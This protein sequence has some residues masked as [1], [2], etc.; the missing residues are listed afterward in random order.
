[1]QVGSTVLARLHDGR[2]VVVE[3]MAAADSGVGRD[4]LLGLKGKGTGGRARSRNSVYS[5]RVPYL[6]NFAERPKYSCYC[7][8]D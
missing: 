8:E 3:I 2:E 4:G 5:E 6:I 1:L 7:R